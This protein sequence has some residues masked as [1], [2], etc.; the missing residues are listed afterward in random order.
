MYFT[1]FILIGICGM[2][3]QNAGQ[4]HD[5]ESAGSKSTD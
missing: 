1:K 2:L 3:A 5:S 4:I